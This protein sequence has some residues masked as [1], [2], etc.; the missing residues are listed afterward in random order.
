MSDRKEFSKIE[1]QGLKVLKLSDF[2]YRVESRFDVYPNT[3][4]RLWKFHDLLT[5]KRGCVL[6][7]DLHGFIP[8]FLK[9]HPTPERIATARELAEVAEPGWWN[10]P[11]PDC[12]FKMRDAG[13]DFF[14][15]QIAHYDEHEAAEK[16]LK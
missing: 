12:K 16:A 5:G 9:S 2:H 3:H 15:R 10:C 8:E 4:G 14:K 6:P 13:D 7:N 11:L 1:R